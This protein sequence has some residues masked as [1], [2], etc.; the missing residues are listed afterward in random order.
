MRVSA[1]MLKFKKKDNHQIETEDLAAK[2]S[3]KN[4]I[5]SEKNVK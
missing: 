2:Q 4:C 3:G 5:F 1:M